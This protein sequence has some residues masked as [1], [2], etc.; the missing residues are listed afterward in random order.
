MNVDA[1]VQFNPLFDLVSDAPSRPGA[2]RAYRVLMFAVVIAATVGTVVQT[3]PSPE[4]GMLLALKVTDWSAAAL[5]TFDYVLRVASFVGHGQTRPPLSA[6]A[7]FLVQPLALFD[8]LAVLPF[9]VLLVV[10]ASGDVQVVGELL[11][12]VKLARY[13]PAL[14]TLTIVIVRERRAFEGALFLTGTLLLIASTAM[15]MIERDAQPDK[16][17]SIPLAMWWGIVTLTTVGYGDVTPVTSVGKVLN[18]FVALLGLIMFALPASILANGFG[19]EIRRRRFMVTWSLVAK[20]PF[21]ARLDA[22]RI[23]ELA[24]VLRPRTA[25]P[26]EVMIQVGDYADCMYFIVSGEVDVMVSRT[27]VRLKD[28]DFFGEM[29]LIDDRPRSAAVIAHSSC[30]LLVLTRHDFRRIV[31]ADPILS[32]EV[33]RI[34]AARREHATAINTPRGDAS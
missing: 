19:E 1:K 3:V 6:V 7:R 8:L 24:G 13:S 18:G 28:G 32:A 10:P 21:F 15:Y 11:R 2:A 17:G 22:V 14:Q 33:K 34:A 27:R 25:E 5:L 9:F 23:A 12:F 30:S 16:F 26:N 20:V 4:T 31:D 29:A